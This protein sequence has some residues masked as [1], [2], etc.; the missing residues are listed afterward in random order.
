MFILLARA[1]AQDGCLSGNVLMAFGVNGTIELCPKYAVKVPDLQKQLNEL[2]KTLNG[3]QELLREVARSARGVNTLGRDVD[4]ERQVLLLRSFD[5]ELRKL[6][7]ADQEKVQR[8]FAD[9]ADKLDTLADIIAQDKEDQRTARQTMDALNSKLGDA[10]AALDIA[11]AQQQ[12]KSIQAKLDEI[13]GKVNDVDQRTQDIQSTLNRQ[14]ADLANRIDCAAA[15]PDALAL[16]IKALALDRT[17]S[18][19]RCRKEDMQDAKVQSAMLELFGYGSF[20]SKWAFLNGLKA[21]K[22]NILPGLLWPSSRY[23]VTVRNVVYQTLKSGN[24]DGLEWLTENVPRPAWSQLWP[25]LGIIANGADVSEAA[26]NAQVRAISLLFQ[27]GVPRDQDNYAQFRWLYEKWLETQ[28]PRSKVM[29][30]D[31][32]GTPSPAPVDPANSNNPALA[33]AAQYQQQH[34]VRGEFDQFQPPERA[35]HWKALSDALAPQ[36]AAQLRSA[37]SVVIS[38]FAEAELE[39]VEKRLTYINA[40]LSQPNWYRK[41]S[42]DGLAR[43]PRQPAYQKIPVA[44]LKD[45]D[46]TPALGRPLTCQP[47]LYKPEQ[48]PCFT[49]NTFWIDD[50]PAPDKPFAGCQPDLNKP[51]YHPCFAARYFRDELASETQHKARLLQLR[52]SD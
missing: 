5:T 9:L 30:P 36:D 22:V 33:W 6:M 29:I 17:I 20:Q 37:Q 32:P 8:Q 28:Y 25:L 10:L 47:A 27:A 35:A 3:N 11:G 34:A 50:S 18:I 15:T 51:D 43:N 4:G 46:V 16:A 2:Q 1:P 23:T 40:W 48:D 41:T 42:Q 13:N 52:A 21:A 24:L 26:T 49:S 14:G 31:P 45:D 39:G 38:R 44:N 19:W 12:L 7:A